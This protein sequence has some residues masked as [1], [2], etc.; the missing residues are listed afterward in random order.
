VCPQSPLRVL[1]NCG[2]QKI[3]LAT[4]DLRQIIVKHW[5]FS[6]AANIWHKR[7]S[8]R[9]SISCLWNGD[10]AGTRTLCRMAFGDKISQRNYHTQFNK[11]PPS[12]KAIRDLKTWR[13]VPGMRP[14]LFQRTCSTE[15]GKNSNIVW[16]LSVPPREPTSMSTEVRKKL[17]EFQYYMPQTAIG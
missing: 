12:D 9:F 4:C 16:T 14:R 8:L 13:S 2:A 1:K 17:P 15:H 7:P 5:K 6:L 11:Q 10:C 3:E